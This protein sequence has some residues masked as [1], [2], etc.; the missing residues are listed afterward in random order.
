MATARVVTMVVV[1]V[2]DMAVALVQGVSLVEVRMAG[3]LEMAA[4]ATEVAQTAAG[5]RGGDGGGGDGGGGDGGGVG[6]GR[7]SGG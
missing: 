5:C 7:G 3:Q 1:L 6:G 2:A 4:D